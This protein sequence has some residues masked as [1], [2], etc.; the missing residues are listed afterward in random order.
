[1]AKSK[2]KALARRRW[3]LMVVLGL[4]VGAAMASTEPATTSPDKR[5][6]KHETDAVSALRPPLPPPPGLRIADPGG[7][8]P[9][10]LG[11]LARRDE[12]TTDRYPVQETTAAVPLLSKE[13]ARAQE[14]NKVS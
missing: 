13:A 12:S 11:T 10:R 7:A 3:M 9:G 1:M 6:S 8:V 2:K 4:L 14:R 5:I